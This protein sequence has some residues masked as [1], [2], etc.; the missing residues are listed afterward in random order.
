MEQLVQYE[1]QCG[2]LG[3]PSS[4]KNKTKLYKPTIFLF[5]NTFFSF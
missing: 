5:S 1:Q 4:L 3:V 2:L